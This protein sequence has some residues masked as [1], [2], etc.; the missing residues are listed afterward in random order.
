VQVGV[1]IMLVS[2][3][4]IFSEQMFAA[5]EGW[6]GRDWLFPHG[7]E[8]VFWTLLCLVLLAPLVAIWRNISALA[9]LYAQVSTAGLARSTK[10]APAVE[11]AIKAVAG[12]SLLVWL[13]M[14]LPT[15]G[16]AR[17]LLLASALVA[18]AA[19]LLLRQKLIFWHSHL[20]FELQ[21]VMNSAEHKMTGTSA[22]WLQ[23]HGDWNLHIVDCVLPDLADVQGKKIAELDLRA[24]SG[25]S[26][27]GIE[28]QGY[29]I[30]I[31][32]PDAA[33]YPR[34][35]VLLMGT[36]EQIA[37]AKKILSA[38]SMVAV[39]DSLFEEVQ[40]QAIAVPEWSRAAGRTLGDLAPART[41][42]VQI[43]GVNRSGVR[44]LNPSAEEALNAGDEVLALGTPEQIREF[45]A[46]LRERPEDETAEGEAGG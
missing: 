31:P 36:T 37:A 21:A 2:G 24:R 25:C 30:P 20:E 43:A 41:F 15:E 42:G 17:W 23:P 29:M 11:A 6:L 5:L 8:V 10:L 3:G 12:V 44:I 39:T 35:R 45:K 7:P 19:I 13:A 28:R 16:T 26:V 1:E 38:V 27:V 4:L 34:D 46:W 32:P 40:M 22:P 14:L 33:L 18:G 9:L